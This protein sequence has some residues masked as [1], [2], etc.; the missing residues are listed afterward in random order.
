MRRHRANR[1]GESAPHACTIPPAHP[2]RRVTARDVTRYPDLGAEEGNDP[3]DGIRCGVSSSARRH[4]VR[5]F[6]NFSSM[7]TR[8]IRA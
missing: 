8:Y 5:A 4:Y 7:R 2:D 3:A 6:L 1:Q